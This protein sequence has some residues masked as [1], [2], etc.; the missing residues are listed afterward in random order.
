MTKTRDYIK[1]YFGYMFWA[2]CE[3]LI[4]GGVPKLVIFPLAAYILG[5]EQFGIFLYALGLVMIVGYAPAAE[6]WTGLIRNT[7]NF[8]GESKEC[9]ISTSVK[10]LRTVM[11]AIVSIYLLVVVALYYIGLIDSRVAWC[12]VL[13]LLLLYS[14]NLFEIQMIRYRV[15]RRFAFRTGWYALL[16]G[17]MF[18]IVPGAILGGVF[19]VAIV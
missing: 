17:F 10:M 6:L 15:E 9:L 5:K 7:V 11:L 4:S 18:L 1:R 2:G 8:A 14:W 13:L 3:T 16:V 19:G 12:M